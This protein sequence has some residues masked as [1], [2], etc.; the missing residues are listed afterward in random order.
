M[1][2]AFVSST[3][4]G[5]TTSSTTVQLSSYTIATGERLHAWVT[6]GSGTAVSE[7]M[8]D[9]TNT[10]SKIGTTLSDSGNTQSSVQFEC[11]SATGGTYTITCTLGSAQV[12]RGIC[13]A[14][15]T[16]LA[17]TGTGQTAATHNV[18]PGSGAG[19][20]TSG[21]LTPA[22]QP[23]MLR[24]VSMD[25]SAT[26]SS[27]TA[28]GGATS[29]GAMSNIETS[30]FVKTMTEDKSITSTSAV[31]ATFTAGSGTGNFLTM[32][33]YAQESGGGGGGSPVSQL[34]LLGVGP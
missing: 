29:R 15:Y 20:V 3:D 10:W 7:S 16:G 13:V 25:D 9:G 26:E 28:A 34:M 5:D 4:F 27:L 1:A 14:R 6:Y 31:A 22:G 30:F 23:G 11:L 8:S 12:Y 19:A 33:Y 32:A 18:G 21:N 24:G 17:S 2:Y